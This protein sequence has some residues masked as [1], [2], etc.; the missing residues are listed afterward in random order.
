MITT[1]N[2]K[3]VLREEL[4]RILRANGFNCFPIPKYPDSY[5]NAKGGSQDMIHKELSLINQ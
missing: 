4:I 3:N 1:N 5:A 2:D